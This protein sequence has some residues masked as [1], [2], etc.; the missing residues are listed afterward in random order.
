MNLFWQDV[1]LFVHAFSTQFIKVLVLTI[2]IT[3]VTFS[4]LLDWLQWR[5]PCFNTIY[6]NSFNFIVSWGYSSV[7]MLALKCSEHYIC[8]SIDAH[9]VFYWEGIC[10]EMVCNIMLLLMTLTTYLVY[11]VCLLYILI[12]HS[13][14]GFPEI[15]CIREYTF[16]F[17]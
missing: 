8:W 4:R 9:D 15:P 11:F 10:I 1:L 6:F 5:I 3:L 16:R 12:L 17:V 2:T 14:F 7:S 13:L